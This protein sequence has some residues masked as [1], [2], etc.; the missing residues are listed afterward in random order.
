MIA[1][2]PSDAGAAQRTVT[3]PSP[4]VAVTLSGSLGATA[5]AR[6]TTVTTEDAGLDPKRF[7]AF[8][9]IDTGTFGVILVKVA[10][11]AVD[12]PSFQTFQLLL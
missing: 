1:E 5:T 9:R 7:T 11:V 12:T 4:G 3:R 10:A 6:G 2:P 8:T